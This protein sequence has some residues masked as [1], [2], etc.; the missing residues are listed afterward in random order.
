MEEK[1][2]KLADEKSPYLILTRKKTIKWFII[3]L[4]ISGWMFILGIMVGRGTA[5]IQFDVKNLKKDIIVEVKN[6][7]AKEKEEVMTK[8]NV[9]M[10]RL[11]SSGKQDLD[12]YE[13][14]SST[15]ELPESIKIKAV[16]KRDVIP[17]SGRVRIDSSPKEP[18]P[19]KTEKK[20][21][22]KEPAVPLK[23]AGQVFTIQVASVKDQNNAEKMVGEL[24]KKGYS[25][26]SSSAEIKG[27]GM[28]HRVRIGEF[29]DRARA[30]TILNKLKKDK[31][32]GIIVPK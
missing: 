18:E 30:E 14:L 6:T 21:I 5:P 4:I 26:Y 20:V 13:D 16:P 8:I 17:S 9:L 11:T 2:K 24:T 23:A 12:F 15:K 31:L 28:W 3:I 27:R 7:I 25:A 10:D 22:T 29:S 32:N 1:T 19:A